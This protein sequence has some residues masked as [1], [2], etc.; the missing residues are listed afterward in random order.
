MRNMI[1]ALSLSAAFLSAA[2]SD[3]AAQL[4]RR[5]FLQRGGL[6]LGTAA[7]AMLAGESQGAEA[8]RD[9][10]VRFPLLADDLV[11]R[12]GKAV[13]PDDLLHET[14][15]LPAALIEDAGDEL[16][17]VGAGRFQRSPNRPLRDPW[18]R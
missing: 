18:C 10:F 2:Q 16:E 15:Q 8:G 14:G 5:H 17:I 12:L 1:A 11:R 13:E 6:C 3:V 4:A 7:L 9:A